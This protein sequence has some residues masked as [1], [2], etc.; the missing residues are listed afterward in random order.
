MIKNLK[1][2][3]AACPRKKGRVKVG[4]KTIEV[5][6]MTMKDRAEF[7]EWSDAHKGDLDGSYAFLAARCCPALAGSTPEQLVEEV[8]AETLAK[9]GAKA[10]ELSQSEKKS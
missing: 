3:S 4:G 2:L 8:S 7:I 10:V 1:E 5:L 9:I 6:E